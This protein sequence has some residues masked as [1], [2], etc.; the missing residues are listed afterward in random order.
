MQVYTFFLSF[1]LSPTSLYL[2]RLGVEGYFRVITHSHTAT[3]GRILLDEGSARR[4]DLYL[5]THNTYNRQTFIPPAGFEPVISAGERLQTHALDRL[6]TGIGTYIHTVYKSTLMYVRLNRLISF[7]FELAFFQDSKLRSCVKRYHVGKCLQI[8]RQNLL[9]AR[10]EQA[11]DVGVCPDLLV[12]SRSIKIHGVI[13]QKRRNITV[14]TRTWNLNIP[15]VR[16]TSPW[17]VRRWEDKIKINVKNQ[18]VCCWQGAAVDYYYYYYYYYYYCNLA[19]TQWQQ[20]Y[21]SID[22]N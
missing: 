3:V 14:A 12:P 4:R 15:T 1:F 21:T 19:F 13:Q 2:T 18:D 5:T 16:V 9:P 8:F 10:S 22:K 20:S 7:Q 17:N 6:A 11:T